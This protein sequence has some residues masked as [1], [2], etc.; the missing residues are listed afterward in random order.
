M[1]DWLCHRTSFVGHA[2][3]RR[4]LGGAS[5]RATGELFQGTV[6]ESTTSFEAATRV[7]WKDG[8]LLAQDST[9]TR[10]RRQTFF[11]GRSMILA[12][13]A[14]MCSP[15]SGCGR[16]LPCTWQRPVGDDGYEHS[17]PASGLVQVTRVSQE[18]ILER[19]SRRLQSSPRE[20]AISPLRLSADR[21]SSGRRARRCAARAS[22]RSAPRSP[23][24][25]CGAGTGGRARR[26]GL[27]GAIA[28]GNPSRRPRSRR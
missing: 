24:G 17:D 4:G 7:T 19:G 6:Y 27:S 5:V 8:H 26:A 21:R 20:S 14:P 9:L 15:R 11:S 13:Q 3:E 2:P 25:G 12:F 16:M 23:R 18:G 22:R 10:P 1:L 28:R